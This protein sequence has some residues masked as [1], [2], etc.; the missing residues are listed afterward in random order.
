[1][2][3][4]PDGYDPELSY[5]LMIMVHGFGANMQDLAGLAPAINRS[6]YVY[7]C[8]NAPIAFDLGGGQL[9]YGWMS[10]RGL[11]TPEEVQEAETFLN[12]FFEEV[13]EQFKVTPGQAILM[14]FSQGGGMTYRCG[15]GRSDPFAGLVALS[16]SLSDPKE[17]EARLPEDRSQPIFVAHGRFDPMVPAERAQAALEFLEG[18]GYRPDYHEYDMGHE[19]SVD[20]LND[21]IPWMAKMMPPRQSGQ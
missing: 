12:G 9:G 20:V 14:G 6:G 21:L 8:P 13:F 4:L 2:T 15:L 19:I 7:A 16:A 1:M 11:A 17:L 18:A 3:I 5:P 10:P